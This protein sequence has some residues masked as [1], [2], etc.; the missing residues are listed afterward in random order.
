MPIKTNQPGKA[1]TTKDGFTFYVGAITINGTNGLP[2][3]NV[4]VR[5]ESR[6]IRDLKR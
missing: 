5:L 4:Q 6:R 3:T 1:F 2:L